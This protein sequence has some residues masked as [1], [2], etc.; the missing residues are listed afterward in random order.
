[1]KLA[2]L[3]PGY[4]DSPDYLHFTI[5]TRRLND[6]GYSVVRLDPC[7][8]WQTGDTN[9]YSISHY[10]KDV[11]E[12]IDAHHSHDLEEVILIGHSLGGFVSI[13]AGSRFPEVSKI[14]ALCPPARYDE[15]VKKWQ[16]DGIRH[17]KRELPQNPDEFRI[18]SVPLAFALDAR[19]YSA[20]EAV[21][22]LHKPF[23]LFIGLEDTVVSPSVTEQLATAASNPYVIRKVGIGHDFR[24]SEQQTT[25]VMD[26]IEKFLSLQP[27]A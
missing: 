13:I 8:V 3:L 27:H 10:L 17:S 7:R 1:M 9:D 11:R 14:I 22:S 21:K 6:L 19:T 15:Y 23:M 16:D 25:I 20:I 26:E 12:V 18:F 5:F 2:I 24:K 4:L